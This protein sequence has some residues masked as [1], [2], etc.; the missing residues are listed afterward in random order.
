M[1]VFIVK[2]VSFRLMGVSEVLLK[3]GNEN[4]TIEDM[5]LIC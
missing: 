1:E 5:C 2:K 3:T 4:F